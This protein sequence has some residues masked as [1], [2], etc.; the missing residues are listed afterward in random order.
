M[1]VFSVK[2]LK[3][4]FQKN[5][6]SPK[7]LVL[8]GFDFSIKAGSITGFLG[9]NG[10]GKTTTMKC[11]LGLVFPDEGEFNYFGEP[12]LNSNIKKKLG[13]LPERP[14][15]YQYLTGH[16]FLVF[17]GSLTG[18]MTKKLLKSRADDLL[19]KMGLWGARD[20]ALRDYSKGMLQKVGLAQALIHE[21]ELVVL[22]EP[23]SGLDPDGRKAMKD[24][25]LEV[26]SQGTAIFFS[27]HLLNDVE[28]L[29]KE[30]VILKEGALM[31]Q[32]ETSKLLNSLDGSVSL[33]DYFVKDIL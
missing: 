17:Y 3:K 9:A 29:C 1:E 8:K 13:F 6:Y 31:Y 10:A 30:L 15:F 24:I 21:P 33:E 5:F 25:I 23:M 28:K 32:G 4:S 20:K 16:E 12:A 7:Q 19:K 27:S 22:D 18:G 26:S 14:Y 11:M 2:G